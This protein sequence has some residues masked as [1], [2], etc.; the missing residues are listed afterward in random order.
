MNKITMVD[1]LPTTLASSAFPN[2]NGRGGGSSGTTAAAETAVV[3]TTSQSG[4]TTTTQQSQ[5]VATQQVAS[6]Q[7]STES[8]TTS[9][10]KK[11]ALKEALSALQGESTSLDFSIDDASG[12]LVVKVV[13]KE[14]GEVVRQIPSE[15]VLFMRQQQVD[16]TRG[17]LFDKVM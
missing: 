3:G 13:D 6:T 16:K 10:E 14:S 15:E 17:G 7:Q 12:S 11:K 2:G 9:E 5:D 8:T 4:Q 1:K